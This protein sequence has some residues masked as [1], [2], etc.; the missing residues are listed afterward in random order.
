MKVR[1]FSDT[2]TALVEFVNRKIFE[3]REINEN[4]YVDLDEEGNL[5]SMT[6][7]HAKANAG[8]REFSYQEV[9]A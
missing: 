1:Y 6:I 2:D 4:I 3:T 8:L 5:V 7:E 9:T